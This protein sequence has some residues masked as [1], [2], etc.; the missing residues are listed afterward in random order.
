MRRAWGR[1]LE[2]PAN[3]CLT[4][5][6]S[7]EP[8]FTG[9]DFLGTKVKGTSNTDTLEALP[10]YTAIMPVDYSKWV[11]LSEAMFY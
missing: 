11:R 4:V 5:A 10:N 7:Y 9:T 1:F 8:L 6:A 2:H 3:I